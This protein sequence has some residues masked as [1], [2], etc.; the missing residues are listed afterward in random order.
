M[1]NYIWCP[2]YL[3]SFMK[4]CSV[5][6]EE[7][8]W[9]TEWRTDRQ[10]KNNMSPHQSGGRHNNNLPPKKIHE[11]HRENLSVWFIYIDNIHT[12]FRN[13]RK[14]QP[15]P[16]CFTCYWASTNKFHFSRQCMYIMFILQCYVGKT[17]T[18]KVQKHGTLVEF[19]IGHLQCSLLSTN[20]YCA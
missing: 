20:V 13:K 11:S 19:F 9:Q 16:K 12:S 10:D 14:S 15:L 8:R 6:S 17:F 4:F 3:P 2:Y 5:V 7:L 18:N 1:H